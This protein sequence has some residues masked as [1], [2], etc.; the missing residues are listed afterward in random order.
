MGR[1]VRLLIFVSVW[2]LIV[3]I[4]Q[5]AREDSV[6]LYVPVLTAPVVGLFWLCGWMREILHI[7]SRIYQGIGAL[8]FVVLSFAII[9][10]LFAFGFMAAGRLGHQLSSCK[11]V[12]E[13]GFASCVYFSVV[14]AS[15]LGYGDL[16]PMGLMRV[17]ACVEVVEFLT[18][19]G[20]GGGLL[21]RSF[22]AE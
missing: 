10:T 21:A 13:A 16:S 6:L 14:T 3:V 2:V 15:T 5:Y 11:G 8:A 18:F 17:L 20:A 7:K 12:C 4:V 1:T 22:Q 19:I 9:G